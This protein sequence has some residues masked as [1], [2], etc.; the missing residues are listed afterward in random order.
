M[1]TGAEIQSIIIL[2]IIDYHANYLFP[3]LRQKVDDTIEDEIATRLL[4]NNEAVHQK[5]NNNV[6]NAVKNTIK[7]KQADSSISRAIC[8]TLESE[9]FVRDISQHML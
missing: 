9:H 5:L 8:R 4:R 3:V 7:D 6:V 2:K 1:P